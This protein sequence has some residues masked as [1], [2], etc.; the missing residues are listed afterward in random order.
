[1]NI[2]DR[3]LTIVAENGPM[4]SGEVWKALGWRKWFASVYPDLMDLER[5]GWLGSEW[6]YPHDGFPRRRIYRFI[7]NTQS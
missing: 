4:S 2:K 5:D 7:R 6:E 1:M 3:I